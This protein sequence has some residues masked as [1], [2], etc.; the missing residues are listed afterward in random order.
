MDI[1]DGELQAK[2]ERKKCSS[3]TCIGRGGGWME[4]EEEK[5]HDLCIDS[6]S[7]KSLENT[8]VI[9]NWTIKIP[10]P[11]SILLQIRYFLYGGHN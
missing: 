6:F 3:R 11:D 10:R 9:T 4:E 2:T 7:T 1:F 5:D 8:N